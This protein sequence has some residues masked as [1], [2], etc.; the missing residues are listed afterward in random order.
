[1]I[2]IKHKDCVLSRRLLDRQ[3]G[4]QAW[5]GPAGGAHHSVTELQPA[6]RE[7]QRQ[8]AIQPR[9]AAAHGRLAVGARA[10]VQPAHT[11]SANSRPGAQTHTAHLEIPYGHI[12]H[13]TWTCPMAS[14]GP[15]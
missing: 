4:K 11:S 14:S 8:A 2:G 9:H 7:R 13:R 12:L 6:D 10:A 5:V 3:A 1:M 15:V